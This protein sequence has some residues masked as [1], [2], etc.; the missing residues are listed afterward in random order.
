MQQLD[1]GFEADSDFVEPRTRHFSCGAR[2]EYNP[3][4]FDT[5][6][7]AVKRLVEMSNV[8][9]GERIHIKIMLT[10]TDPDHDHRTKVVR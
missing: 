7:A 1:R 6:M 5:H 2:G 10:C 3:E 8:Q 9:P 4:L